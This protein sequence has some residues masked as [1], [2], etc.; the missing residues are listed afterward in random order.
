MKGI[1]YKLSLEGRQLCQ[2]WVNLLMK[3]KLLEVDQ[4][5]FL[6]WKIELDHSG[7]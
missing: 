5:S 1:W 2:T 7:C 6:G 4:L 3:I